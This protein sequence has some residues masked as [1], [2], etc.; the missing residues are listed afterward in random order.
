MPSAPFL[1]ALNP[2]NPAISTIKHITFFSLKHCFA[3]SPSALL[4]YLYRITPRRQN[5][6]IIFVPEKASAQSGRKRLCA[7]QEE[8]D[9]GKGTASASLTVI[10]AG[11]PNPWEAVDAGFFFLSIK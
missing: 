5:S 8:A 7:S 11:F 2:I 6:R 4:E 1:A 3:Q 10:G 9:G